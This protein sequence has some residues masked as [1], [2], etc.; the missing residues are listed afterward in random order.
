AELYENEAD[1]Y[2]ALAGIVHRLTSHIGLLEGRDIDPQWRARGLIRRTPDGRW[3]I[4]N[5]VN[6][7]E[8]FA[9]RWHEDNHA[10]AR[11]FFSWVAVLHRDLVDLPHR[12]RSLNLREHLAGALG[13]APVSRNISILLP[14]VS[15]PPR[16]TIA[17]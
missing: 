2:S 11:A 4:G 8:N 14:P 16:I 9:D 10:R 7:A 6:P 12:W 5:P 3:Y 1:V 17:S 15:S 13:A